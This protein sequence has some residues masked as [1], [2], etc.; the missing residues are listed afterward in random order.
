MTFQVG[1]YCVATDLAA[2]NSVASSQLGA[3][4]NHGGSLYSVSVS[5]VTPNQIEYLLT[6]FAPGTPITVQVPFTPISC[7]LPSIQDG[8]SQGWM[9][10]TVWLGVFALVFL[11]RIFKTFENTD[12]EL[13]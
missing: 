4:V 13:T 3:I 2:A 6:P 5:G 10:A 12:K 1:D 11:G 7:Q 8:I 9:V